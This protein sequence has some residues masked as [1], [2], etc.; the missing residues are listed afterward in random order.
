MTQQEEETVKVGSEP[1]AEPGF[2]H[3][4][5]ENVTFDDPD[6]MD[7]YYEDEHSHIKG[8]RLHDPAED[9]VVSHSEFTQP[10]TVPFA[11][12]TNYQHVYQKLTPTED[13]L[14]YQMAHSRAANSQFNK[15]GNNW[16]QRSLKMFYF[17][18]ILANGKITKL[19]AMKKLEF[20]NQQVIQKNW[21][22]LAGKK[23]DS[24]P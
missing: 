19:K 2:G 8:P 11:Q 22:I 23:K 24:R 15:T 10:Y 20:N 21:P 4:Q 6:N 18:P 17:T 7:L 13:L 1:E 14:N 9:L 12:T 5:V 16:E 3:E